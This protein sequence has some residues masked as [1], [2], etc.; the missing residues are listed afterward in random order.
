MRKTLQFARRFV[1][2]ANGI[3]AIEMALTFPI[4]VW[5]TLGIL[6]L[7][8]I[9]HITSL[10]NYAANEAARMGKTGYA[11][12]N[13]QPTREQ[14]I[15]GVMQNTLGAWVFEKDSLTVDS[16]V[17]G[18]F[19]QARTGRGGKSGSVGNSCDIVIYTATLQWKLLTPFFATLLG[20]ETL[21]ISSRVLT[22]NEGYGCSSS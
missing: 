19:T 9:F 7:G 8:I 11:F 22:K 17:Y 14:Q 18:S 16:Q 15:Y 5:L 1:A 4:I 10:A 13:V 12:Y 20:K 2:D 3:A 21:P 6:E